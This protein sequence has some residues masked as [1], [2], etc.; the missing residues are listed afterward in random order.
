MPCCLL[1]LALMVPRVTLFLMWLFQYTNGVFQTYLW[2]LLGFFLMPYTT[3]GY[4]FAMKLFGGVEGGGLALIII[5]VVLDISG[6]GGTAYQRRVEYR[7]HR[8]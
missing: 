3:C 1:A 6:H 7:V 8:Y 5:G 4:V 2:P